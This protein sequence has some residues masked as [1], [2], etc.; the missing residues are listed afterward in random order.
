[1]NIPAAFFSLKFVLFS[2]G[3]PITNSSKFDISPIYIAYI[4]IK[5]LYN[6]ILFCLQYSLIFSTS[7]VSN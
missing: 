4:A 3:V 7:F 2:I 5:K 6:D 1:M